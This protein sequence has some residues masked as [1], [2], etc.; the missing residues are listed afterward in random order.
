MILHS[1]RFRLLILVLGFFLAILG[2]ITFA[3]QKQLRRIID[4]SQTA[5]Y[6]EKLDFILN[7]LSQAEDLVNRT[8]LREVY[9]RDFQETVLEH[10]REKY[11]SRDP[12]D[13]YPFIIDPD[14][15]IILH[16]VMPV[17]QNNRIDLPWSDNFLKGREGNFTAVYYGTEKWYLYKWFE[18]WQW[19]VCYTV[20]VNIKYRDLTEFYR[21][22]ILNITLS[23]I[24]F[25]PL[26]T[27]FVMGFTRPIIRLTEVTRRISEGDL[28]Q[29]LDTGGKGELAVL[30]RS[31]AAMQSSIKAQMEN[32]NRE[33]AEKARVK[34]Q[35]AQS[36]KMD[37]IG[38]LAGG[39]A[40]DFNN[41]LAGI[42]GAAQLLEGQCAGRGES[43]R[44][45]R[46][47][48]EASE[49]AADLTGKLLAFGKKSPIRRENGDI[50]RIIGDTLVMLERTIDKRVSIAVRE[51]AGTARF[52]G[53]TA[54]IQN[55]LMNLAINAVQAMPEG[56]ALTIGTD[57]VIL[58]EDF[59]RESP[60]EIVPGCYIVL[61]VEDTGTGI[62]GENLT[63][64]F[65]P[66]FTTKDVGKG[67][68]LGLA[69]VYG[70]VL[71]HGGAI[72][73]SSELNRGTLFRIFLPCLKD[74]A[75]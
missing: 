3:T 36:R 73:V 50:H 46:M 27:A 57:N 19:I 58:D 25:V 8:G 75:P 42:Y 2:L 52:N 55:C 54:A 60:F 12:L 33:M 1:I 29:E 7:E 43:E 56:G 38:Q 44:H 35:L 14:I 28:N 40:H 11:Y 64:I 63:K 34:E 71:D 4:T 61:D 9:L 48:L 67:T 45:I 59:C 6:Y 39:V 72:T 65:E 68:G 22:Q 31:F 26:L 51:G 66:F 53:D 21:V 17:G 32:L 30:S 49:R 37:A 5:L 62:P 13:D 16:P 41:V 18:P 74:G 23:L 47:I 69:S 70:T 15:L 24:L 10:I 20:P